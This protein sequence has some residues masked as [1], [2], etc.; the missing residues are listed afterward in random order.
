MT[1]DLEFQYPSATDRFAARPTE[2]GER[3]GILERLISRLAPWSAGR[4]IFQ[5]QAARNAAGVPKHVGQVCYVVADDAE[6]IF[7]GGT[8]WRLWNYPILT[9][10]KKPWTPT[11]AGYSLGNGSYLANYRVRNGTVFFEIA[12]YAGTTST[13]TADPR[14]TLPYA[15]D[16]TAVAPVPA[17][18]E[19]NWIQ[20]DANSIFYDASGNRYRLFTYYYNSTTI[21]LLVEN[22]TGSYVFGSTVGGAVPVTIA[23][24]DVIIVTGNYEPFATSIV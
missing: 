9:A 18:Q 16:D 3:I 10:T 17:W 19:G 24:G 21:S 20:S 22:A 13:V 5:N 11:G 14:W 4:P 7:V 1:T 12:I 6:W 2:H 15:I 23:N 8:T